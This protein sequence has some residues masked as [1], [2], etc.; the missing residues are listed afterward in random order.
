M[1]S[2]WH[3]QRH[4]PSLHLYAG[5]QV[6]GTGQTTAHCGVSKCP[7]QRVHFFGLITYTSFLRLIA[8]FGHSNSHAP[9][10]VHWDAIIL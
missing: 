5:T 10:T 4:R 8:T 3:V 9:Q 1:A 2:P 6:P 7:L